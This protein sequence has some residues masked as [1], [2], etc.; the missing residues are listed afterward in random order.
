[1]ADPVHPALARF[2]ASFDSETVVGQVLIQHDPGGFELR[3]VGDRTCPSA[4]LERVGVGQLRTLAQTT[5]AGAFRPLKSAPNLRSGWRSVAA[6]A[7]ELGVALDSLH[8]GFLADWLAAQS[9]APPLTPYREFTQRQTG[10]YRIT[11]MLEDAPA[12]A[13]VATCCDAQ[14]CLKRRWWTVAALAPDA[15]ETKSII[16]CLEPCAVLLEFARQAQRLEQEERNP[17]ALSAAERATIER[18]LTDALAHPS[19]TQ[20]EADFQEPGNPRRLALLLHKLT[21]P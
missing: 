21:H 6:S 4:E 7:A 12:T 14:F 16:P 20:R 5:A 11:Q 3:H 18:A 2:L 10:M 13:M 1:M 8:P 9:G 15:P 19:A 17:I